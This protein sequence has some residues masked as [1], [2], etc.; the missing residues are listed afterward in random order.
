MAKRL[1]SASEERETAKRLS[2]DFVKGKSSTPTNNSVQVIDDRIQTE[3]P[4]RV[5]KNIQKRL[6]ECE[7]KFSGDISERWDN[8]VYIYLQIARDCRLN[9][10]EMLRYLL[11]ILS[12]DAKRL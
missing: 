12:K 10:S 1:Y 9:D 11:N 4:E 5:A 7:S 6:K 8:S 3:T 2:M